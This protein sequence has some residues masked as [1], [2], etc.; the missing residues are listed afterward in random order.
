MIMLQYNSKGNKKMKKV[1]WFLKQGKE[2][3]QITIHELLTLTSN[4]GMKLKITEY[5]VEKETHKIV[6][7]KK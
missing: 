6:E 3:K 1:K 4:D 5:D 7:F 2:I